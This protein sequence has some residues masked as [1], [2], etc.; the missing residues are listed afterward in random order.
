MTADLTGR[1]VKTEAIQQAV[2][3][4]E[5]EILSKL[6]IEWPGKGHIHCPY[7]DHPDNDPSWRWDDIKNCA[8][9]TCMVR[10]KSH[11]IFI[12]VQ[13]ILNLDFQTAKIRVAELL[14]RIDLII[15]KHAG[16]VQK[17]DAKSLLNPPASNRDDDLNWRYLGK[18]LGIDRD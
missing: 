10:P 1:Y 16:D 5:S 18:R 8:F 17:T 15:E 6:G 9:C 13:K 14:D 3:G 4:H 12:V 11:T 2:R 7:P